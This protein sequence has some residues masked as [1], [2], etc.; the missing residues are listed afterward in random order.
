MKEWRKKYAATPKVGSKDQPPF[1]MDERY[2]KIMSRDDINKPAVR[3]LSIWSKNILNYKT[4]LKV[5]YFKTLFKRYI[6]STKTNTE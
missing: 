5:Y 4:Y 6:A 1:D 2:L 3:I